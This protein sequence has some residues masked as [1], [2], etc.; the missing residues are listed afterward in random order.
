MKNIY[1]LIF[2]LI[3]LYFICNGYIENFNVGGQS[4]G[5][6]NDNKINISGSLTLS[7]ID[8]CNPCQNDGKYVNG[9][10]KCSASYTGDRCNLCKIKPNTEYTYWVPPDTCTCPENTILY[11]SS[12]KTRCGPPPP[13]PPC[14]TKIV[15]PGQGCEW[16]DLSKDHY[17]DIHD[18]S[19]FVTTGKYLCKNTEPGR[20]GRE[21]KGF[22]KNGAMCSG[23]FNCANSCKSDEFENRGKQQ[24]GNYKNICNCVNFQGGKYN[25]QWKS[26]W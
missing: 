17:A 11:T 4:N 22:C 2:L 5:Q 6:D 25:C 1:L 20:E 21:G 14:N 15:F 10:C 9:I 3:F 26:Y 24:C 16:I 12:G 23:N 19:K 8:N 7:Y 13:P 18:C